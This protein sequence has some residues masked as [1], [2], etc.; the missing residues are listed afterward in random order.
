[1]NL[2]KL[3]AAALFTVFLLWFFSTG[4]EQLLTPPSDLSSPKP[5]P[6]QS[7]APQPQKVSKPPKSPWPTTEIETQEQAALMYLNSLRQR[8]SLP[9]FRINPTLS[10]AAHQHALYSVQNNQQSHQE[11]PCPSCPLGMVNFSGETPKQR[12][13]AAGYQ[14]PVREVIAYNK[15]SAERL[16]DD[17]MSAIY[18]RLTLLNMTQDEIGIGI[19]DDQKDAVKT[20]LVALTGNATLN[21]L[22]QASQA[23]QLGQFYYQDLCQSGVRMGQ[24]DFQTALQT[25][26]MSAPKLIH[27]PAEN[28]QVSPVFY[29]EEPDPLPNCN[30]SGF[31]VHVQINPIYQGRI[32]FVPRSFKVYQLDGTNKRVVKAETIFTN[33]TDP[34]RSKNDSQNRKPA[35]IAFFPKQRLNWNQSYQAE[36]DWLEG[37][38]R[39][40]LS[41][42]FQTEKQPGLVIIPAPAPKTLS[43]SIRPGQTRTLYFPP[44]GCQNQPQASIST[45]TPQNLR[46]QTQFID[47]ET[48]QVKL[49]SAHAHDSFSL[50]YR[51]TGTRVNFK[52]VAPQTN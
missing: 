49:I 14:S 38:K 51:P 32:T 37:G 17:L 5:L 27:W 24:K 11:H 19:A 4:F 21:Q 15:P 52:V 45:Q 9:P 13:F 48:L 29:E 25:P 47:G 12:A 46:I 33:Q 35:W 40:T 23:T 3:L 36:I 8:L 43:V 10:S 18:H 50:F 34:N 6:A 28:A 42:S 31:P 2:F 26:A 22:C 20:A 39:H 30:V 41:W 16:I 1:M 44:A 7:I